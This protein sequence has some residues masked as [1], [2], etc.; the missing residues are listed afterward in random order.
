MVATKEKFMGKQ[1]FTFSTP[2]TGKKPVYQIKYIKI[3]DW[4]QIKFGLN[5]IASTIYTDCLGKPITLV[6]IPTGGTFVMSYLTKEL[7]KI[8]REH[9]K[10]DGSEMAIRTETVIVEK[11]YEGTERKNKIP[12]IR[13]WYKN[14]VSGEKVYIIE[15]LIHTGLTIEPVLKR[16]KQE[17]PLSLEVYT[18]INDLKRNKKIHLHG[19]ALE[20]EKNQLPEPLNPF[21]IGFA[22][23][24][25]GFFRETE[26]V[27]IVIFEKIIYSDNS[28]K[29]LKNLQ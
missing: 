9:T 17:N 11:T 6:T 20:A 25:R 21:W 16:I 29:I 26:W 1:V 12:K 4:N 27:G 18:L 15:D 19:Y 7:R 3:F 13:Q 28:E 5:K 2:K 14:S 24:Y 22:L 8:H 10:D 23:D